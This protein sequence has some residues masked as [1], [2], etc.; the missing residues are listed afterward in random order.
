M[1][2]HS[3]YF[4]LIFWNFALGLEVDFL[5]ILLTHKCSWF[6]LVDTRPWAFYQ[7]HKKIVVSIRN[8]GKSY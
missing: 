5:K 7:R 3:V 1:L 2:A 4:F 8:E 6:T